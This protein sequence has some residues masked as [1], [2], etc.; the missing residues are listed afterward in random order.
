LAAN[1]AWESST[2]VGARCA[3]IHAPAI[4]LP[5]ADPALVLIDFELDYNTNDG[6]F[7]IDWDPEGIWIWDLTSE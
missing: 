6:T 1:V 7:T 2:I 5:V 4:L 3:L